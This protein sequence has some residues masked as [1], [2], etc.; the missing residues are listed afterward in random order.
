MLSQFTVAEL[1]AAMD[2]K[3]AVPHAGAC[4]FGS[5]AQPPR[6]CAHAAPLHAR[7]QA[8]NPEHGG[9]RARRPRRVA[10]ASAS[11]ART[12]DVCAPPSAG[13]S[14]LTDSLVA[15][16]GI[17][18]VEAAGDLRL[19]DTR[20]DEQDRCVCTAHLGICAACVH[21]GGRRMHV[22][23]ATT[24]LTGVHTRRRCITIK[25]TGISLFYQL[26]DEMMADYK[27]PPVE[28]T[29]FLIN[30]IDSPGH[31]D[32]SSEA[33]TLRCQSWCVALTRVAPIAGD[34]GAAHH[35][36]RAGGGGLRGGRE[37]ADGDC[38]A[39]GAGCVAARC[40]LHMLR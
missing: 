12:A 30:L 16:A 29:G 15:A 8:P 26:R 14:T 25:S 20:Q 31:V 2:K 23:P 13:K 3:C 40:R 19:T 10:A 1:R 32:F 35:G 24:E 33:R 6:V 21:C 18:A 27:G 5:S 4:I 36:R 34:C 11:R 38:A 17:I 37:R 39:P 22:P 9:Y 7:E 28:G